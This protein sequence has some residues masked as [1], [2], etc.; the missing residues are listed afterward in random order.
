MQI[1]EK[2]KMLFLILAIPLMMLCSGFMSYADTTYYVPYGGSYT[3]SNNHYHSFQGSS[4]D[5]KAKVGMNVCYYPKNASSATYVRCGNTTV[6][7]GSKEVMGT[8]EIKNAN[9]RVTMDWNTQRYSNDITV[10]AIFTN[11]TGDVEMWFY[12]YKCNICHFPSYRYY[13]KV[14]TSH[15]YGGYTT[16]KDS[17]S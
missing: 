16:V 10:N 2:L 7:S 17:T 8:T 13:L 11:I 3:I 5:N 4:R 1:R 12:Y 14:C 6:N 15:T 9:L